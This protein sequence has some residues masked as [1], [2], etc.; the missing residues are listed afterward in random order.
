MSRRASGSGMGD[1]VE[2]EHAGVLTGRRERAAH[3][4]CRCVCLR[5]SQSVS[6]RA[7]RFGSAQSSSSAVRSARSPVPARFRRLATST[8]HAFRTPASSQRA[9]SGAGPAEGVPT[10]MQ[11]DRR[12]PL[13]PPMSRS[14]Q[15]TLLPRSV[16]QPAIDL[17]LSDARLFVTGRVT[18]A[19]HSVSNR[20]RWCFHA[21]SRCQPRTPDHRRPLGGHHIRRGRSYRRSPRLAR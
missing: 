7:R 10:R 16:I 6:V 15:W 18:S 3:R 11:A 2:A 20:R 17:L 1:A 4:R 14:R 12:I 5:S 9:D 13:A 19:S 21:H 8:A